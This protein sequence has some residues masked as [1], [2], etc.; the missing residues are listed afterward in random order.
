[1]EGQLIRRIA[2]ITSAIRL[3]GAD[4]ELKHIARSVNLFT[5]DASVKITPWPIKWLEVTGEMTCK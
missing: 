2:E 4:D 3:W 5:L 1:M